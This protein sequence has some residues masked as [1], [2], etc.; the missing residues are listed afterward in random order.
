[1][2]ARPGSCHE[3][4]IGAGLIGASSRTPLRKSPFCSIS[5]TIFSTCR[6]TTDHRCF[7]VRME[8]NSVSN[9]TNPQRRLPDPL[10]PSLRQRDLLYRLLLPLNAQSSSRTLHVVVALLVASLEEDEP[11]DL[12][13]P[14][15]ESAL[16]ACG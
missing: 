15:A 8:D 4:S 9:P 7:S 16:M 14:R 11:V 1:M 5:L 12:V 2:L 13:D 3:I 10:I 6:Q